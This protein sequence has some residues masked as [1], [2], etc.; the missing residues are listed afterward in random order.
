MSAGGNARCARRRRRRRFSARG[1]LE[2]R[3]GSRACVRPG[4]VFSSGG[5]IAC[6]ARR[7]SPAYTGLSARWAAEEAAGTAGAAGPFSAICAAFH[8]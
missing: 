1:G 8:C 3:C 4:D 2:E 6:C 5:A 7:R